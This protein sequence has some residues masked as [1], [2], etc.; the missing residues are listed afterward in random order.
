MRPILPLAL[1][2]LL[3]ATLRSEDV[4]PA[5]KVAHFLL[6][7]KVYLNG[8]GPFRMIVDSGAASSTLR[9]EIASAIGVAP[10]ARVEQVTVS[11]ASLRL[12]GAVEL[13]FP[14]LPA[15]TIEIVFSPVAFPHA[16]GVLGQSWL[17]RHSYLLDF[18][19]GQLILDGH[20]PA[21]GI[22]LTRKDAEGRP[23]LSATVD[24]ETR[25]LVLDSGAPALILFRSSPRYT[26]RVRLRTNNGTAEASTGIATLAFGD[27]FR[28][29]LQA[30]ELP[31]ADSG[32]LLPLSA[33]RAV[34]VAK[35]DG[36]MVLVPR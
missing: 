34:Y 13:S 23:A 9:P 7:P 19:K 2:L 24:G 8:K 30:V 28:Q 26:A 16:D 5:K 22:Q 33:F 10:L 27:R 29:S 6:L 1:L 11:G 36:P 3:P 17:R 31:G 4:L 15:E 12:A 18:A 25:E 32:G 20:P 21:Q 14:G 35:N